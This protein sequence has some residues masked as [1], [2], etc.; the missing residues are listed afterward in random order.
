MEPELSLLHSKKPSIRPSSEPDQS[1]SCTPPHFLKIPCNIILPSKPGS[2]K[3]SLPSGFPTK[4]LYA[5]LLSPR[6]CYVL[7]ATLDDT[8]L[9]YH[10]TKHHI[11][12]H[13]SNLENSG[14]MSAL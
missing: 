5:P 2:S 8:R 9:Y 12:E 4:T 7:R 1:S 14:Y 6:K 11:L 3:G 13:W 10:S